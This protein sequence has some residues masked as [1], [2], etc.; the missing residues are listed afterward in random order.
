MT[1]GY[2]S[3][4]ESGM[5]V[6]PSPNVLYHLAEATASTTATCSCGPESECPTTPRPHNEALLLVSRWTH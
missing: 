1:N 4:I 5:T 2:L 6:K 3:Q